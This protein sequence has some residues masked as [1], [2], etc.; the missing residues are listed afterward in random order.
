MKGRIIAQEGISA[1]WGLE[2]TLTQS[3]KVL[4]KHLSAPAQLQGAMC[5]RLWARGDL[6]LR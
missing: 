3:T 5:I 6:F 2:Q 1:N 4:G